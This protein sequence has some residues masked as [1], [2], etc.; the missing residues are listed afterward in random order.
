MYFKLNNLSKFQIV[1]SFFHLKEVALKIDMYIEN[2]L[3]L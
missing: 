3:S 1:R 2:Y